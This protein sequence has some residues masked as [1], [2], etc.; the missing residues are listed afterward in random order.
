[1]R[2]GRQQLPAL[3]VAMVLMALAAGEFIGRATG[4][5]FDQ[6]SHASTQTEAPRPVFRVEAYPPDPAP[7][8]VP[9]MRAPSLERPSD[10]DAGDALVEHDVAGRSQLPRSG[11]PELPDGAIVV[12]PD[13]RATGA[14]TYADP[15]DI[16]TA[17]GGGSPVQPGGSVLLRGGT[18]RGA[19]TSELVG[20]ADRPIIVRSLPGE[21]A[22]LDAG[23]TP[24]TTLTVRGSDTWFRDFEVTRSDPDRVTD[25]PGSHPASLSR[26]TGDGVAVFGPRTKLI[27]LIVHDNGNGIGHWQPAI[28]AEIYGVISFNNGW[29]G[30][31]RPH[32]HGIYVQNRLGTKKIQNTVVFNNFRYGILGYGVNAHVSGL[33]FDGLTSFENGAPAAEPATSMLLG[34][35]EHPSDDIVVSNSTFYSSALDFD[36][37]RLGFN[38]EVESQAATLRDNAFVGGSPALSVNNW[39]EVTATDNLVLGSTHPDIGPAIL[40]QLWSPKPTIPG[41]ATTDGYVWDDNRYFEVGN[42]DADPGRRFL[43]DARLEE[44]RD[45]S[46]T[47]E[48]W[49]QRSGLDARST[50][51]VGSPTGVEVRTEANRYEPGRLTITVLNW[52]GQSSVEVDLPSAALPD[53]TSYEVRDVE[54]FLG[55]PVARGIFDGSSITLTMEAGRVAQPV[56][57]PVPVDH[58]AREL[59]VFVLLPTES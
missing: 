17:L 16:S 2:A 41:L 9:T 27:N 19:F 15:V 30:P 4:G 6:R 34:A 45:Q 58:T 39:R 18:Y 7:S 29:I 49:R 44:R 28:D 47:F 12:A 56:G 5:N 35:K 38:R 3:L 22:V 48:E 23:S 50:H 59:G 42:G 24:A 43:I 32:G 31:D 25:E 8:S 11:P 53:G 40:G 54:N 14:G 55:P 37:V 33:H 36:N 57:A 10:V 20:T 51:V 46:M 13:G 21:W 26:G 52:S 1:M